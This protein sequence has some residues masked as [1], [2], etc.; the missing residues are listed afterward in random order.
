MSSDSVN[1]IEFK[2]PAGQRHHVRIPDPPKISIPIRW[3]ATRQLLGDPE[4][5]T[6]SEFLTQSRLEVS[7]D[8]EAVSYGLEMVSP[9][10][11]EVSFRVPSGE[12]D[13]VIRRPDDDDEG[14]VLY[15]QRLEVGPRRP[16][17]V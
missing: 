3:V 1:E 6:I 11:L 13:V 17:V 8:G 9:N 5:D 16:Y 12:H 2:L 4:Q 7:I 15:A 14:P 10:R